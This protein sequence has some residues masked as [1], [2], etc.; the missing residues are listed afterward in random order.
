MTTN[1]SEDEL[2]DTIDALILKFEGIDAEEDTLNTIMALISQKIIE[3]RIDELSKVF[4]G[5]RDVWWSENESTGSKR[6]WERIAELKA[7]LTQGIKE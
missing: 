3:A 4:P 2:R 7:T 6:I 1:Q 5:N